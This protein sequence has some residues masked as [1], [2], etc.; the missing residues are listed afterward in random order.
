GP[1]DISMVECHDAFTIAEI[2]YY[3]ALGF[4]KEGEAASFL[5]SG[6]AELG[7]KHVFSPRGGLLTMGHPLGATGVAQAV[8]AVWQ[9]RGEAG[10]RQIQGIKAAM[11]HITGGGVHGFDNAACG[12]HI[13][14]V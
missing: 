14:T 6:Q 13:Y 1:E 12:I 8:E 4:C 2:L 9:L 10:D 3:E 7:G 5:R 11:T